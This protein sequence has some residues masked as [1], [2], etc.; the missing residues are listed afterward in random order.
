MI[1]REGPSILWD[2]LPLEYGLSYIRNQT[3]HATKSKPVSCTPPWPLYQLLP[4]G[5]CPFWVP[6]W[7]LL[8]MNSTGGGVSHIITIIITI[9]W[10]GLPMLVP[11]SRLWVHRVKKVTSGDGGVPYVVRFE[12]P[13]QLSFVGCPFRFSLWKEQLVTVIWRSLIFLVQSEASDRQRIGNAL[14]DGVQVFPIISSIMAVTSPVYFHNQLYLFSRLQKRLE[15]NGRR[16]GA[17]S[18]FPG[19]CTHLVGQN[20]LITSPNCKGG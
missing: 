7:F 8:V 9:S 14:I 11:G 17:N 18:D 5:S 2:V 4:P 3:N 12:F 16:G 19:F 13:F 1:D 10:L 6:A 15:S 20:S